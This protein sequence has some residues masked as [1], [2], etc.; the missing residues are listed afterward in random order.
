[1][2][3]RFPLGCKSKYD[4]P[5]KI[6]HWSSNASEACVILSKNPCPSAKCN[7]V[8]T[9]LRKFMIA[10]LQSTDC[11]DTNQTVNYMTGLSPYTVSVFTRANK[12]VPGVFIVYIWN[13]DDADTQTALDVVR[14]DPLVL[15]PD[16]DADGYR[17]C[18][19]SHLLRHC[20]LDSAGRI[21][22]A[23]YDTTDHTCDAGQYVD[24][25]Y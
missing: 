12:T 13:T 20:V 21:R 16:P 24:I 11:G 2:T 6:S 17:M 22:L 1:M 5:Y 25:I 10:L 18:I 4:L 14:K 8:Q 19:S 3:R 15:N 7:D 9:R 23:T